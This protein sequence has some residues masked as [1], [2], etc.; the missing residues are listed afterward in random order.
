MPVP[1][2]SKFRNV[3][4][5]ILKDDVFT[6]IQTAST[7][8]DGKLSCVNSRWIS[9]I[10]T[11]IGAGAVCV[12]PVN[13]PH[14][15]DVNPPTIRG[16]SRAVLD[17]AFSPFDENVLATAGDDGVVRVWNIPEDGFE[18]LTSEDAVTSFQHD[19]KVGVLAWHPVAKNI[20]ASAGNDGVRIWNLDDSSLVAHHQTSDLVNSL[21]FNFNGSRLAFSS[22]DKNMYIID[23]RSGDLVAQT[24]AH[25]GV[26]PFKAIWCSNPE[27]ELDVIVTL[28]FGRPVGREI[29]VWNPSSVAEPLAVVALDQASSLFLPAYD[30]DTSMLFFTGKGE[31]LIRYYEVLNDTPYVRPLNEF[32][33]NVPARGFCSLAK[34]HLNMEKNEIF[35]AYKITD[36]TIDPISFMVP[37]RAPGMDRDIFPATFAGKPALTAAEWVSGTD[38]NPIMIELDENGLTGQAVEVKEAPVVV[39]TEP[40]EE[41]KEEPKDE[42]K[43]EEPVVEE[44]KEVVN[45]NEALFDSDSDCDEEELQK[46]EEKED[47]KSEEVTTPI[48]EEEKISLS[49]VKQL[50]EEATTPLKEKIELLEEKIFSL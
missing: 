25:S 14:K 33:S 5:T 41:P 19:K 21:S 49:D 30:P 6:G 22:K 42:V 48:V 20:L 23:S 15:V 47:M 35:R 32:A 44:K 1:R 18:G 27:K 12:L 13:N 9:F 34:P 11:S 43:Q 28:G 45:T 16:H 10:M 3:H 46:V 38:A 37:R 39:P 31:G 40:K 17:V 50:I 26:K 4:G 29:K 24:Q 2:I 8:W 36:K 7:A